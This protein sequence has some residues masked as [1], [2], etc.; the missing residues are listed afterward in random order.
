MILRE[1]RLN[2]D[3][4]LLKKL[5]KYFFGGLILLA[6]ALAVLVYFLPVR[7]PI[8][9]FMTGDQI[10]P[11]TEAT[12]GDHF[13]V[14]EGFNVGI[15][16]RM[17]H[18]RVM[19]FTQAGDMVVSS[20]RPGKVVLIKAD[21]DGDGASD[22]QITLLEG[23]NAPH[24]IALHGGYLYVAET[25]RIIRYAFD[26]EAGAITGPQEL[27]FDGL[28]QGGGHFTRTIE[29]GP[30]GMLYVSIGS[31]CNVCIEEDALR[32]TMVQM[33]ADGDDVQ[34]YATG[35]RNSVGFDWQPG[36][37]N[38]FATDN[39]RDWL[40]DDTPH[41]ELNMI[42][43]GKDYGWP[44]AYDDKVVDP[45]YGVD[46]LD[47]VAASTG[48]THGFGAHRAPLGI[49]FLLAGLEPEGY[50]G[51]ALV[52]LHGSWNRSTLAG[53]KVVSLHLAGDGAVTQ[54]DFLTGFEKDGDVIGRP[55]DVVQGPDGAIYIADDYA[56]T[57]YKVGRAGQMV[58][59]NA[60]PAEAHKTGLES[61]STAD[62][63]TQVALGARLYAD[64]GCAACHETIEGAEK[65]AAKKLDNIKERF[66][67][68][69]LSELLA[70]PPATMPKF[71]LSADDRKA[72]AAYLLTQE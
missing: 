8:I 18:P 31:S 9:A 34:I 60:Q 2:K 72:L 24:G 29:F 66:S 27:I 4:I 17:Q 54:R 7:G 52:A 56:A 19:K 32:A 57:I 68:E 26:S 61:L 13:T 16:A 59:A 50:E 53:Y 46:N 45:D 55:A 5:L 39:G 41:C 58:A 12:I 42:E 30:D 63:A 36:S 69:T 20:M 70:S 28:P 11:P 10:A 15:F 14:P 23:L 64:N 35:L 22:G 21:R 71:T 65:P 37:G 38:L 25:G 40:G 47:K 51:A 62:L 33:T 6:V 44:Y 48:L 49:R 43:Q 1:N 3:L 67:V